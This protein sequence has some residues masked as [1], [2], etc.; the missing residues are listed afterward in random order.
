MSS[1]RPMVPALMWLAPR[2]AGAV[3][4][5]MPSRWAPVCSRRE[6]APRGRAGRISRHAWDPAPTTGREPRVIMAA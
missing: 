3:V 6:G 4:V 2:L 1:A 5:V